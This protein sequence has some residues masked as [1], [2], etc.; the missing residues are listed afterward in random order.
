MFKTQ[1][2]KEYFKYF[3][4]R[5]LEIISILIIVVFMLLWSFNVELI[6]LAI[7]L[8]IFL[9]YGSRRLATISVFIK[10]KKDI[11]KKKSSTILLIIILFLFLI[12]KSNI[13]L[14]IFSMIFFIFLLYNWNSRI[15]GWPI[16][17]FLASCPF[18]LMAKKQDLAEQM[19]IYAYYFLIITVILQIIELIKKEPTGFQDIQYEEE[20]VEEKESA[21]SQKIKN[22]IKKLNNKKIIFAIVAIAFV[23][24]GAFY[25]HQ[26]REDRA[27]I[28]QMA[29]DKRAKASLKPLIPLSDI[30]ISILNGSDDPD[31]ASSTLILKNMMEASGFSIANLGD[32][33]Q[34][35][36][37]KIIIKY[38][39]KN[40]DKAGAVNAYLKNYYEIE[41]IEDSS[42]L[43]YDVEIIVG[44]TE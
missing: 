39:S 7:F 2:L 35:D 19:A 27:L 34:Y 25:F 20:I 12:W 15:L 32:A 41:M 43:L 10:A 31:M 21:K 1:K 11:R 4:N 40:K 13:E 16:S 8:F 44:N 17:L 3:A 29:T 33:D 38:S 14:F 22:I 18:F 5:K 9:I 6:I 24:S 23:S 42:I 28:E 37:K 30:S 36:Y 26:K